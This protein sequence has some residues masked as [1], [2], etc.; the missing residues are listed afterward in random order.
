MMNDAPVVELPDPP[1]TVRTTFAAHLLRVVL[2]AAAVGVPAWVVHNAH[3][4]HAQL[5]RLLA[6]GRQTT[7]TVTQK[8]KR[9]R[10]STRTVRYE[11]V[12]DGGSYQG[13]KNVSRST[14]DSLREGQPITVT[15][16][17]ANPAISELGP[18]TRE[19]VDSADDGLLIAGAML[20]LFAGMLVGVEWSVRRERRLCTYGRTA[21]G[22]ITGRCGSKGRGRRYEFHTDDGQLREATISGNWRTGGL[23][24]G[25][26]VTVLYD[27][28]DP[29]VSR[30]YEACAMI[31]I[32]EQPIPPRL[33]RLQRLQRRA[34]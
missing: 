34:A 14:Y 29:R 16:L 8:Y 5:E 31:R 30:P 25:D 22:T 17:P 23:T 9:S 6:D 13:R 26:P 7:G 10:S 11:Y 12:I 20:L 3:E 18:V 21:S 1:R 19:A 28:R 27:P 24:P 2:A 33:Q 15:F 4:K 32:V